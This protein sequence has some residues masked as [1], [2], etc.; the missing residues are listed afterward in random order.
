LRADLLIGSERVPVLAASAIPV[1]ACM[2]APATPPP[3][4]FFDGVLAVPGSPAA[5]E[6]DPIDSLPIAVALLPLPV[7]TPGGTLDYNVTLTNIS[8]F[9]KPLNLVALCPTY[10]ERLFVPEAR[11]S[12]DSHLALN[13]ASAG[14]LGPHVPV[15]F[16]MRLPIPANA[17]PG[18]ASLVWQLGERGPA[19][20]S[21]FEIRR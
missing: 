4:L 18:T 20:K 7:A 10:T 21:T 14:V 16:A 15:T 13:C 12:L 11:A 17:Q 9:D 19:A 1:P 6:P 5:P 8:P 2:A 3:D